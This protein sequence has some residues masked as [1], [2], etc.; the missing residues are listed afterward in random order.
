MTTV[1]RAVAAPLLA[2]AVLTL[3]GCPAPEIDMR[4]PGVPV[5]VTP[6]SPQEPSAR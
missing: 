2:A 6:S 1:R 4:V 3:A 5:A